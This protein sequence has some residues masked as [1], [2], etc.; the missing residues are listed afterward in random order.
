[1]TP[2]P[3]NK[4]AETHQKTSTPNGKI[5]G[6]QTSKYHLTVTSP[7]KSVIEPSSPPGKNHY[8]N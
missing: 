3:V 1:M 8:L 4:I 6:Q 5:R 7:N 2:P